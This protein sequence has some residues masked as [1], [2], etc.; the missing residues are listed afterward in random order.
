MFPQALERH[1]PRFPLSL[2]LRERLENEIKIKPRIIYAL[3]FLSIIDQNYNVF[4]EVIFKPDEIKD[5]RLLLKHH[6]LAD[7][8]YKIEER[9]STRLIKACCS[10]RAGTQR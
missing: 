4:E 2:K 9:M 6:H 5:S 10:W 7:V 1:S 3:P 8:K